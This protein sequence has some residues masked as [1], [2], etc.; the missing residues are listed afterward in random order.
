MLW[1]KLLRLE[2]MTWGFHQH[3]HTAMMGGIFAFFPLP[4][5]S[6]S[7]PL[8]PSNASKSH[9]YAVEHLLLSSWKLV[10]TQQVGPPQVPESKNSA[11]L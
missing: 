1:V 8:N 11:T 6:K 5:D 7:A 4:V 10:I 2:L 9:Q 3:N